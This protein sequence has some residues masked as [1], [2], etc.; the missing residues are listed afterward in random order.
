MHFLPFLDVFKLQKYFGIVYS[1]D[2]FSFYKN[3]LYVT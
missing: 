1:P 2:G 3:A